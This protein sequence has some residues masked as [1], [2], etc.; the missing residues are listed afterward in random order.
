MNDTP[1]EKCVCEEPNDS[2]KNGYCHN[3]G[4]GLLIA[5][6]PKGDVNVG[7]SERFDDIFC[8]HSKYDVLTTSQQENIKSFIEA[9][10]LSAR[11]EMLEKARAECYD[12]H[13]EK[14]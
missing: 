14:M 5:E 6:P 8:N 1:V 7:W 2:Y 9:E 3:F 13:Y 12:K 10:I 4:C 11:A